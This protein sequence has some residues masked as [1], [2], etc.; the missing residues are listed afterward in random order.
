MTAT[1]GDLPFAKIKEECFQTLSLQLF[2]H[3]R[4]R[5]IPIQITSPPR[6]EKHCP[7]VI[8]SHGYTIAHTEYGFIANN[9][10]ST[11]YVVI[12]LQHDLAGDPKIPEGDNLY[13]RRMPLWKQ[14]VQN[15]RFVLV[16]LKRIGL[17]PEE[18]TLIGHSNGGD[19]SM[20]FATE[21]AELISK[22][23]SLDSLRMP[24]PE[25]IPI[26]TLR[27]EDTRADEGVLRVSSNIRI[28]SLPGAKHA[29]LCDRGAPSLQ[30][31]IVELILD[32]IKES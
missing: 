26:L 9:L 18:I 1:H 22:V 21:S 14:G 3:A 27:A 7:L 28:V 17:E 5:A 25:T 13:A 31:Q 24:F 12:S 29:D 4:G 15:I 32:F 8:I 11:G 2:D 10:A 30:M 23:V 19:I 6:M 16:E 20:L